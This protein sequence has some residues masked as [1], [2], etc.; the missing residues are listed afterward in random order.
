MGNRG[1][2]LLDLFIDNGENSDCFLWDDITK[3]Y[4][5][6]EKVDF[7]TL[8]LEKIIEEINNK[9]NKN[10]PII[11]YGK[12]EILNDR[13]VAIFLNKK[14]QFLAL[15]RFKVNHLYSNYEISANQDAFLT[16]NERCLN[17]IPKRNIDFYNMGEI[18]VNSQLKKYDIYHFTKNRLNINDKRKL[19][20]YILN[21]YSNVFSVYDE[22]KLFE[23]NLIDYC[24]FSAVE[25]FYPDFYFTHEGKLKIIYSKDV[26]KMVENIKVFIEDINKT[27]EKEKFTIYKYSE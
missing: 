24:L 13:D 3:E 11:N 21:K 2:A 10:I 19:K 1:K 18:N 25:S 23:L 4:E 26:N 17:S 6:E 16:K 9:Y 22:F 8:S 20:E 14:G 12:K 27:P 7:S 15:K 5:E